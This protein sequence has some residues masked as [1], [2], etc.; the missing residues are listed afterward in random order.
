MGRWDYFLL[1]AS[2][3][4][5]MLMTIGVYLLNVLRIQFRYLYLAY[6]WVSVL[7]A[8]W[9][10]VLWGDCGYFDCLEWGKGTETEILT[11]LACPGDGCSEEEFSFLPSLV[12]QY[13]PCGLCCVA[14]AMLEYPKGVE[15]AV[16]PTSGA[17]IRMT[18]R[19]VNWLA[20]EA[21]YAKKS[22]Q[23]Q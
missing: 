18:N 16:A 9:G 8:V 21:A 5:E 7:Q 14:C 20:Q 11:P 19:Y 4:F 3:I 13:V 22:T 10:L 2:I 15:M 6:I 23:L 17:V 12:M 1:N